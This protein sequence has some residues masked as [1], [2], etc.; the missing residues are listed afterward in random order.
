[1]LERSINLYQES[2][3]IAED[4]KGNSSHLLII[5]FEGLVDKNHANLTA[6]NSLLQF[7]KK[8]SNTS[9]SLSNSIILS[10]CIEQAKL[11]ARAVKP[12]QASRLTVDENS[13]K[14]NLMGFS[15]QIENLQKQLTG[16]AIKN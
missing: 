15:K 3:N 14:A 2:I 12:D 11:T 13:M 16:L 1:M 6:F 5:S 10:K 4:A 7:I 8:G 9:L